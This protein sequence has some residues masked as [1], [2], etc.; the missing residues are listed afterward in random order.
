MHVSDV[1]CR[2]LQCVRCDG[3]ALLPYRQELITILRA[4]LHLKCKEGAELAGNL[5]RH[6]LKALTLIYTIDYRS[7]TSDWDTPLDE[8]LPIRVSVNKQQ[9]FHTTKSPHAVE[10]WN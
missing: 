8:Y 9:L 2:L 5:L 1:V 7:T 4:T 3:H 6:C 10:P